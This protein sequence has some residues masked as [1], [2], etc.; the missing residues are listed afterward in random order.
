MSSR[1]DRSS[2]PVSRPGYSG[3]GYGGF[4]HMD[5]HGIVKEHFGMGRGRPSSPD[6]LN[7]RGQSSP[8]Y[9]S[10]SPSPTFFAGMGAREHVEPETSG[11]Y[12]NS[13]CN[14]DLFD[15]HEIEKTLKCDEIKTNIV[16]CLENIKK[17][18]FI[19]IVHGAYIANTEDIQKQMEFLCTTV[20]KYNTLH[21]NT[22]AIFEDFKEE[23]LFGIID[24]NDKKYG[25]HQ[26]NSEKLFM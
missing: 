19:P 5:R 18:I 15:Q 16:E 25:E 11:K 13:Y 22:H 17:K 21:R 24:G 14:V 8:K 1:Y 12:D 9:P 4:G 2:S 7:F 3:F 20:E 6:G 10:R 23:D 26:E